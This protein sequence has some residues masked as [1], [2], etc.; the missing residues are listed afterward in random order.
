MKDCSI[1]SICEHTVCEI[2]NNRLIESHN[3]L[4]LFLAQAIDFIES[5]DHAPEKWKDAI[6]QATGKTWQEAL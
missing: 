6:K 4:V 1:C 5:T 2:P 3:K